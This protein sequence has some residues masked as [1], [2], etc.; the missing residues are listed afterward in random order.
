MTEKKKVIYITNQIPDYRKGL[1]ERLGKEVDLTIAH[2][3]ISN[4]SEFYRELK[5][6]LKNVEFPLIFKNKIN[7]EAFEI[8]IIWGNLRLFELYKL[9]FKRKRNFKLIVFGP[10]VSASYS[11]K[12]DSS[13]LYAFIY[14]MILKKVDA[15]IFYDNYPVIKYSG[16]G[17]KPF[18]LFCAPNTIDIHT[19][20][21]EDPQDR[22]KNKNT[23]LF[24]GTLYKEKGTFTLLEA[25]EIMYK[26]MKN[27]PILNIVGDGPELLDLKKWV[28][29]H[30]LGE[31]IRFH[32]RVTDRN[33]IRLFFNKAIVCVSPKQAGLSV[34]ESLAHGVPFVTSKYPITGGEYN[35]LIEGV[36]GFFFDETKEGLAKTLEEFL[37]IK[38]FDYYSKNCTEYYK[39]FRSPSLW[40]SQV[41]KG[42]NYSL[43]K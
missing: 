11:K 14:K 12:Y 13:R 35:A 37:N 1:Y 31:K 18:K 40:V 15:A 21:L 20:F 32:G 7:Y 33:Q 9:A 42:I 38:D 24:F 16:L 8:V 28:H 25:Y 41:M 30:S 43:E 22:N 34:I 27:V 3:G 19:T 26:K 29:D 6:E 5:L 39:R 4:N 17:V 36:N 10:G 23:I 2:F